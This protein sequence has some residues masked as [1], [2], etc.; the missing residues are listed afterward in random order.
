ML[1][2]PG[3]P[4]WHFSDVLG[5]LKKLKCQVSPTQPMAKKKKPQYVY[6]AQ[7]IIYFSVSLIVLTTEL[8]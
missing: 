5:T 6:L 1:P 2:H 3:D 8:A 4:G 7:D